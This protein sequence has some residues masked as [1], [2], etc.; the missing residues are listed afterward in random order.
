MAGQRDVIG[1]ARLRA[2]L[3]AMADDVE[4]ECVEIVHESAEAIVAG[5]RARVAFDTGAL[6]DGIEA[7]YSPDGLSAEV[8]WFDDA[9]FYAPFVE[10]GT[11]AQPAQPALGPAAEEER[12]RLPERVA[13]RIKTRLAP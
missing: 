4:A 12:A 8:G 5:T 13:R 9:L 7:R 1:G 2:D 3:A 11:S 10:S 6:Y